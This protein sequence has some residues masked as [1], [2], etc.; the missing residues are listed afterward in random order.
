MNS[1]IKS[2]IEKSSPEIQELF[3]KLRELVIQ[4]VSHEVEEKMWAKLPSYFVNDRFIRLIP[5][6]D[7]INVEASAVLSH[8]NEFKDYK[9]TP[10][11][12]VQ[13]YLKQEIPLDLLKKV[14]T[15][16]LTEK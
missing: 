8:I 16:T 2:C 10:K 15:E 14:F 6:N 9:I 5:F 7:H 3:A 11:G 4:S 13:I 1:E 12:M